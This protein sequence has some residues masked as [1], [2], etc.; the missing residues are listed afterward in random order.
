MAESNELRSRAKGAEASRGE[1][2]RFFTADIA[3]TAK[4]ERTSP[5]AFHDSESFCIISN[6]GG[7]ILP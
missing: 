6:G 2:A 1:E 7:H 5:P 4:I 3:R